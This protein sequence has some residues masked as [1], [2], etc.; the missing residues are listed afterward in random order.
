MY[1]KFFKFKFMLKRS[2][3]IHL[4]IRIFIIIIEIIRKFFDFKIYAI[5]SIK[6]IK[7]FQPF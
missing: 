4:Y 7:I 5:F 1:L 6:Q 2:T 3:Y